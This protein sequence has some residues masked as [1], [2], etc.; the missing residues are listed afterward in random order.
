MQSGLQKLALNHLE[1]SEEMGHGKGKFQ[2]EE[3]QREV[4]PS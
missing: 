3:E 2:L 1:G 4:K